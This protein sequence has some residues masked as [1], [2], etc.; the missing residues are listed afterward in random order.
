MKT[1]ELMQATASLAD[2]AREL[3]KEPVILTLGGKPYAALVSIQNTDWETVSLSSNP[4][5]VGLIERSRARQKAEGSISSA[6]M[7]RRLGLETARS[8]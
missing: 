5:F 6:E 7:R 3:K 8:T 4:Q 2:Y 1:L